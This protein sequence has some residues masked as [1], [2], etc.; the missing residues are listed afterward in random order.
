[1]QLVSSRI[2]TRVAVSISYD[3]NYYTT[4]TSSKICWY[5]INSTHIVLLEEIL[6]YKTF[7]L[8]QMSELLSHTSIMLV[9][10]YDKNKITTLKYSIL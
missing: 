10:S 3:G 9:V 8:L 7:P 2:W 4:G 5:A 1:M 6:T